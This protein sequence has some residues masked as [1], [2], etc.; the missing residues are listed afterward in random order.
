M[1]QIKFNLILNI[2][3]SVEWAIIFINTNLANAFPIIMFNETIFIVG[4]FFVFASFCFR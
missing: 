2:N 3:I 1:K 4:I